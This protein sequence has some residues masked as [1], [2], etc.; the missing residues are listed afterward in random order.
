MNQANNTQPLLMLDLEGVAL[1]SEERDLLVHP[2]VGG[3]ILFSR[4]YQDPLQVRDLVASMRALRPELLIA[5]DQEGGRV[6][7]LREGFTRLPAM[8]TLGRR[9]Q[10]DPG[11]GREAAELLGELMADEVRAVDIDI[12]FAPVLDL[13]Y[14]RSTV[15][16]NRSFSDNVD[17][18]ITLADAFL[19]GMQR[20]GMSATGKHFPGHGHVQADSHLELPEDPRSLSEMAADLAPFRA[21]A[22]RLDGIMPAHV[23]YPAMDAQ[24]AGFSPYWLQKVLREELG[25]RGVIFSDDLTMAGA[26][27][28]GDYTQRAEAALNAGCDMVLVCNDRAG[29]LAVLSWLE[30]QS[31]PKVVP[32]SALRARPRR[33][34]NPVRR[35][36]A[37]DLAE[38]LSGES[39]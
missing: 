21:L 2:A 39:A 9:Y 7:R 13:D 29:A 20:A 12:S 22:P 28:A 34:M 3:V 27:A 33:P 37:C 38:Q 32:A 6:Q 31:L 23:R 19:D 10:Q 24:P 11:A 18:L 35:Q 26:A 16:G 36:R 1:T 5:V 4:N 8:G 14:G 17:V 15:I 25:F 30:Q